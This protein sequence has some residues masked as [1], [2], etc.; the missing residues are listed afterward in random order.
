MLEAIQEGEEDVSPINKEHIKKG[1][2]SGVDK[3]KPDQ[4]TKS[5]IKTKN[6]NANE[7]TRGG[8]TRGNEEGKD[9]DGPKNQKTNDFSHNL[10]IKPTLT[11]D[12]NGKTKASKDKKRKIGDGPVDYDA[13]DSS[14]QKMA[15]IQKQ[16]TKSSHGQQDFDWK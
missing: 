7:E 13:L 12:E 16:N 5:K 10:G 6:K 15:S 14:R 2:N 3:T 11:D 8:E 1:H 9:E 4:K